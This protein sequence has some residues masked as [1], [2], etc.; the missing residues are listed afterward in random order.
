MLPVV[1]RHFSGPAVPYTLE[2]E[3]KNVKGHLDRTK[4]LHVAL[5]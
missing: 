3:I 1:D 4:E 2:M 5:N